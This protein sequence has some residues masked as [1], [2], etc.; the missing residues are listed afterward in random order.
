LLKGELILNSIHELNPNPNSRWTSQNT[1]ETTQ[2][3]TRFHHLPA[4]PS[5]R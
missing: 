3:F 2:N 1:L 5:V 4:L